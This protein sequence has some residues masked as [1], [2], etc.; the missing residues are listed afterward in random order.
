MASIF[1]KLCGPSLIDLFFH[2]PSGLIDRN[3]KPSVL[4]VR[5]PIAT[6][7]L[8]SSNTSRAATAAP[9]RVLCQADSGYLTLVFF[10]ARAD[11]V[12]KTLPIG[13]RRIISGRTEKYRDNLQMVHPDH[14]LTEA[15]FAELPIVEPVYPMTVGITT[16]TFGKAIRQALKQLNPS[17]MAGPKL[18]GK[19][20]VGKLGHYRC[21]SAGQQEV[22]YFTSG[23][24]GPAYDELLANQ[25]ALSLAPAPAQQ[26]GRVLKKDGR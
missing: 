17:G 1:D 9:Y 15:E 10:N 12:L 2:L 3:Y 22:T 26:P 4:T 14:I 19:N 16:K 11:W 18:A 13:A 5:R 8:M 21:T 23:L 7:R 25:L 20:G 24:K 6:L